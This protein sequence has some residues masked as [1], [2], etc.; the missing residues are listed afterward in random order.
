M[1]V[2]IGFENTVAGRL[3]PVSATLES[4]DPFTGK[5]WALIPVTE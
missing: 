3:Q 1:S 2:L 5:P 4:Y